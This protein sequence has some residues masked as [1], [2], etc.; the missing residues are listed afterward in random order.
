MEKNILA[1]LQ[2]SNL[3]TVLFLLELSF[4]DYFHRLNIHGSRGMLMYDFPKFPFF[5]H[6]P[7]KPVFQKP[8]FFP[9][10]RD[11]SEPHESGRDS[12]ITTCL[13]LNFVETDQVLIFSKRIKPVLSHF[14]SAIQSL[15]GPV[16]LHIKY[17]YFFIEIDA[18]ASRPFGKRLL[19]TG[20]IKIQAPS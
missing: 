8:E 11:T 20:Q 10:F 1:G 3:G 16:L 15:V 19:Y 12:Y 18:K 5:P 7:G 6:Y 17:P 14:P 13:D 9:L 4:Q 2:D